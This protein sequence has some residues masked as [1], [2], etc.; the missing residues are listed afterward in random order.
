MDFMHDGTS[1]KWKLRILNV[2]DDYTWEALWMEVSTLISGQHVTRVLDRLIELRGK[3]GSLLN[4]NGPVSR[5]LRRQKRG[6]HLREPHSTPG[7]TKE[8]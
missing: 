3:L 4:D 2:V 1:S 7:P 5:S 6:V 8:K